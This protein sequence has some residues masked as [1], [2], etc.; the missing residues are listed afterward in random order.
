MLL[1][2]C[3]YPVSKEQLLS[4]T[5]LSVNSQSIARVVNRNDYPYVND[6]HPSYNWPSLFSNP[7]TTM[8]CD[9][10]MKPSE[11][12]MHNLKLLH[13]RIKQRVI[14]GINVKRVATVKDVLIQHGGVLASSRDANKRQREAEQEWCLPKTALNIVTGVLGVSSDLIRTVKDR[15]YVNDSSLA[16]VT[17][18]QPRHS[19]I[20]VDL[21][22][23]KGGD[24]GK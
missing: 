6:F 21:C 10:Q 12:E 18:T 23:G 8:C 15:I 7:S 4:L 17:I 14:G 9:A 5:A 19:L 22:C 3:R 1:T 2:F 24:L 11:L 16:E 13:N 20:V